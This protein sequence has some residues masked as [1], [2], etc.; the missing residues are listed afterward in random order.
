MKKY[1]ISNFY[2]FYI[3]RRKIFIFAC[4]LFFILIHIHEGEDSHSGFYS[5]WR[6]FK[7]PSMYIECILECLNCK[8]R[9]NC[10]HNAWEWEEW[11]EK[12]EGDVWRF[13]KHI[14]RG[15]FEKNGMKALMKLK[16]YRISQTTDSFLLISPD[17][18]QQAIIF[19]ETLMTIDS[20]ITIC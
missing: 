3:L 7:L 16:F 5:W 11:E 10:F 1:F 13:I 19:I 8:E 4:F 20:S 18:L 17:V 14:K 9:G 15:L 2:L 6:N 12:V